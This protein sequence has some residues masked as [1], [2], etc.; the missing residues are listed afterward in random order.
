[1]L[2]AHF[3]QQLE[4]THTMEMNSQVIVNLEKKRSACDSYCTRNNYKV[5][6]LCNSMYIQE[7]KIT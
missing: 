2:C 6:V 7:I 3:F 4:L 5:C 1:M